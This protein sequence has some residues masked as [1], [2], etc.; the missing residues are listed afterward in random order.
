VTLTDVLEHVPNPLEIL[1]HVHDLLVD[2]GWIGVKVPNAPSQR[3][4]EAMRAQL[5]RNYRPRIADN[6]VHINHFS[7]RSLRL[8][9]ARAGYSHIVLTVG[10]PELP[11][12][13]GMQSRVSRTARLV[14][15]Y[16][17]RAIP[18]GMGSPLAFNLQAYARR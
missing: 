3:L 13:A 15:F 6:L 12:I 11:P 10:A 2:E 18:F 17:A 14:A 7:A 9:L 4:K 8:A 16:G 5:Q 1:R